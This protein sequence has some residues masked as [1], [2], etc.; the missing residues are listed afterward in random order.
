MSAAAIVTLGLVALLVAALA[1]YLIWI[2]VI[3]SHVNDTLG[4]V[5]FGVRAVAHRTGPAGPALADVSGNLTAVA[6]ALEDFAAKVD[7][8]T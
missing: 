1:F 5:T 6:D 7:A 4:K 2:V 3:L 8:G